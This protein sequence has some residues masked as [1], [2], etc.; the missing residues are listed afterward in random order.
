MP[1]KP[2]ARI[3][4]ILLSACSIQ[5][6][7]DMGRVAA[8]KLLELHPDNESGYILLSNLCASAGMWNAVRKLGKEMK[9]NLLLKEPGSSWIQVRGSM[10][11]FFADDL[12]HP[13][14]KEIFLELKK[15]YEHIQA[16][17]IMEH[18]GTIL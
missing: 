14:H 10:H 3:W 12:L 4:Q 7:V 17:K 18:D 8:S 9:E 1:I 2:D 5:G 6:N 13:E 15:L 11:Y 16:S